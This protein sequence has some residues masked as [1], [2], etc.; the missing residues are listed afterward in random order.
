MQD[1]K[2]FAIYYAPEPGAFATAA[3]A[4][5]GWDPVTGQRQPQPDLGLDLAALTDEPRKYGFHGTIKPPFR[6][7]PG[8]GL[9]DL[10]DQTAALARRLTPVQM[11]GLQLISLHG[12]LALVP[13]GDT[14]AVGDLAA[15]VVEQ[16]DTLR[17]PLT[18]AEIAR[19]RPNRLTP[20]QRALLD[21]YGYPHVL[22]EFRFH[23]TL[24]GRLTESQT[25]A[26][27]PRALAHFA[28]VQPVPF[29]VADL[30]L[31]GEAADGRFH[32]LNRY[33]LG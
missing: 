18:E 2:R 10:Q 9:A 6:L 22:E 11:P 12:F 31:F 25:T 29:R 17:A 14:T 23:L 26:L 30:C 7:A 20:R 13:Q 28:P 5:L 21:R 19:R 33:P 1:F 8:T 27:Q 4:W 16:L 3:A 15:Q 32:L 24:S